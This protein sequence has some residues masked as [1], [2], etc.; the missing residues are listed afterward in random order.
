[1]AHYY[2][3]KYPYLRYSYPDG[4]MCSVPPILLAGFYKAY[5]GKTPKTFFD[6][7]AA[8]GVIVQMALDCGMDAYG[9]EI[10]RY[11]EQKHPYVM[12]I[13]C[14][15]VNGERGYFAQM[16]F[17]D[18]RLNNL[19]DSGR[20]QIKSILDCEPVKADLVYCNGI[21]TYFD[22]ATLSRVLAKFKN[23]KMLC[24]IHNT[25][26]DYMVAEKMGDKLGTCQELKTVKSNEWWIETFNQNGFDAVF[27]HW[28][29]CFVA[30]PNKER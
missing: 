9:V 5:F 4:I 28:L 23:V 27:N 8:N 17:Q 22:E 19:F 18:N 30:I 10:R 12:D 2:D 15:R 13:K 20:I 16:A 25:T 21:L 14:H 1:M 6:C 24:A 26:E 7:G 11:G 3:K 29:R